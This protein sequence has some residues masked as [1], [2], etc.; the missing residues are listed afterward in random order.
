M[1][2]MHKHEE[3]RGRQRKEER[4]T[5]GNETSETQ[6]RPPGGEV[7]KRGMWRISASFCVCLVEEGSLTKS[8]SLRFSRIMQMQRL[9]HYDLFHKTT[10][11]EGI[12]DSHKITSDASA[13][14]KTGIPP[15]AL[16]ICSKRHNLQ[17]ST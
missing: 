5:A 12:Q 1:R 10:E 11:L 6:G 2:I 4:L 8:V 3:E 17:Y 7:D 14:Q 13:D 15:D 16:E 9:C